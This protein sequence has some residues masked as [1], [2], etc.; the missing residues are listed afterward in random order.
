MDLKKETKQ[1]NKKDKKED[2]ILDKKQITKHLTLKD[3]RTL[4]YCEFKDP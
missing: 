4:A 3:G 2:A 1:D